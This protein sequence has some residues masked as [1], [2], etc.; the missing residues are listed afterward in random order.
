MGPMARAEKRIHYAPPQELPTDRGNENEFRDSRAQRDW[1]LAQPLTN[2][3]AVRRK[4]LRDRIT[5]SQRNNTEEG[6]RLEHG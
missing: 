6:L 4:C 2:E 3:W 1:A 5:P